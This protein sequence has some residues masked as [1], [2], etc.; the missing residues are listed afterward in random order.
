MLE[1]ENRFKNKYMDSV[2][3]DDKKIMPLYQFA[4]IVRGKDIYDRTGNLTV[5]RVLD[6]PNYKSQLE[7]YG[8]YEMRTKR[9]AFVPAMTYQGLKEFLSKMPGELADKHREYSN[10]VTTLVEAGDSSMHNVIDANAASS[11]MVNQMAR[12]AV[13]QERASGGAGIA[14]P[15]EQVLERTCLLLLHLR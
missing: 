7:K 5:Q 1:L 12:D 11:N 8:I 9:G 2:M 14:A 10:Y 15:P 3:Y 13:E 4:N 6:K